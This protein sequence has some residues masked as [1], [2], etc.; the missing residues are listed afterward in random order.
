MPV[1]TPA[2]LP[3]IEGRWI[4][5]ARDEILSGLRK[6]LRAALGLEHGE[7]ESAVA[8]VRS[9]LDLSLSRHLRSGTG[10]GSKPPE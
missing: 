4:A 8:L 3:P 10:G 5:S 9:Q 6:R 1:C 7:I 2:S